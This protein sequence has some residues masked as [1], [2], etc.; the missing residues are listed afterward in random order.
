M[1]SLSSPIAIEAPNTGRGSGDNPPTHG[2]D[3]GGRGGD[4]SPN[5]GQRLRRARLGLMVGLASVTMIF[6]SL[7]SAL[8]F[9]QGLPTFDGV[10]SSYVRDW[11][12]LNLPLALLLVNTGLLLFSS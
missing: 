12:P 8:I 5:Y 11:I 10:T 4:G 9:R 2:G 6:V 1:S 7:T 3:S